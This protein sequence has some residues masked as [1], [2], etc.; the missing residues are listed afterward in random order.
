MHFI[1]FFLI[2]VLLV[3][4]VCGNPSSNS[5]IETVFI[6]G[7]T[8]V[9]GTPIKNKKDGAYHSDEAP[10]RITVGDFRIGKTPVTASQFCTFLNS[11]ELEG[12]NKLEYIHF[13]KA[14]T[15]RCST[16]EKK[17]DKYLPKK[18]VENSKV[19]YVTWKGAV[20]FCNWLSKILR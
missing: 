3:M 8:F 6:K 14:E 4:S 1:S 13:E 5:K 16:I 17:G 20:F 18:G 2:F 7:G 9:M 19:Y 12:H 10:I 11:K 15:Q